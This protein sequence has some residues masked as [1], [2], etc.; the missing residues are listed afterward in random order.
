M[1]TYDY[2]ELL[3]MLET[4]RIY[5]GAKF[6]RFCNNNEYVDACVCQ[7]VR[8]SMAQNI[9]LLQSYIFCKTESEE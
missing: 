3:D 1:D 5:A 4:V 9:Q 8:D 6:E 7:F 2:R